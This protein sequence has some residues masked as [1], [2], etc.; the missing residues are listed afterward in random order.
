[1]VVVGEVLGSFMACHREGLSDE[2]TFEQRLE[3]SKGEREG[4][5]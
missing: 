1:M 5:S 4:V 3:W 2:K